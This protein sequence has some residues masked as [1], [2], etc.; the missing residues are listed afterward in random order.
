[1]KKPRPESTKRRPTIKTLSQETGFSIATIS[2][3]LNDSP[4][5]TVETK[6]LIR[7]AAEKIGYQAS[8]RGMSLRTG[9]TYQ[10]AVLM[11]VTNATDF[12]WDGVE[13]TQILGGISAALEATP[14]RMAVH[15][16]RDA[17]DGLETARRIVSQGLADGLIFSGIRANDARIDYLLAAGFPFVTMGR[18]RRPLVYPYVDVDSEWAA[19]A[20]TERLLAGGHKRI[21][22]VNPPEEMAYALAKIDG[23][24]AAFAAAGVSCSDDLIISGDLTARFGKASTLELRARDNP[25]TGFVCVNE[26]TTLG[27]LAGLAELSLIVGRDASV[28]AYDD[29]NVSAYFAPPLTTLYLPIARLGERLGAFLLRRLAGESPSELAKMFRPELVIRQTDQLGG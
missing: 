4:V 22:L 14:Y 23:F 2:K 29:I 12:E 7:N 1:M 26:A 25:P 13:Y 17:E 28:I 21:A 15:I 27:V 10:I 11:P 24:R 16:V 8:L 6:Q 3:A 5:V 9:L 18:C 19:Y 20:A